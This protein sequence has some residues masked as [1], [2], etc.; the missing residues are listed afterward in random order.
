MSL[1][2]LPA[3]RVMLTAGPHAGKT[4]LL[5]QWMA[6][7]PTETLYLSLTPEDRDPEFFA[8]RLLREQPKAYERFVA[9]PRAA[10]GDRLAA[11]LEVL[12]VLSIFLDDAHAIEDS[13]LVAGLVVLA[14]HL[15]PSCTLVVASRH[16]IPAL[17]PALEAVWGAEHPAWDERP[18]FADLVGLPLQLLAKAFSLAL[19]GEAPP[20]PEG[21]ELIR[22]NVAEQV[23]D[24]H[25]LRRPWRQAMMAFPSQ[26]LAPSVW[27]VV[28]QDLRTFWDLNR[29]TSRGE[30]MLA[31]L[32]GIPASIRALR[33]TL[34][35]I[36]GQAYFDAF[37][38][39]S[40]Y[41]SFE[42]ALALR[43]A[44]RHDQLNLALQR[45]E[46]RFRLDE[47]PDAAELACIPSAL[48]D[49]A[50]LLRA[51]AL[52]NQGRWHAI[53]GADAEAALCWADVAGMGAKP[54][55]GLAM[56][57]IRA[58]ANLHARATLR[59]DLTA[60]RRHR[61]RI[62]VLS[63]RWGFE[64]S[65]PHVLL[66]R[67]REENLDES[68][69]P[70]SQVRWDPSVPFPPGMRVYTL[71]YLGQRARYLGEHGLALR[72]FDH[73]ERLAATHAL[74]YEVQLA[75]LGR[76][77]VHAQSGELLR[78][79]AEY[80]A[81]EFSSAP[82]SWTDAARLYW[83]HCL[84][85]LGA[86]DE[87]DRQIPTTSSAT[88]RWQFLRRW[89]DHLQGKGSLE[90]IRALVETP[91]G[92]FLK[93][94]E[95]R[96]L[97]ALGLATLPPIFKLRVFGAFEVVRLGAP[98]PAWPRRRS[99][100]LLAMLGL[101]PGGLETRELSERIFWDWLPS[102]PR[103]SLHVLSHAARKALRA[104]EGEHLIETSRGRQRLVG[105]AF[106]YNELGEFEHFFQQGMRDE[107][108][109]D[110]DLAAFWYTIA[111][112]HVSGDPCENLPELEPRLR[113]ALRARLQRARLGAGFPLR[114]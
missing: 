14:A 93:R 33:P 92:R 51:R 11:A 2:M 89:C 18:A 96:A 31:M 44:A 40:A 30:A 112:H 28:E 69:P 5:R 79:R 74:S 32:A 113:E 50:P 46:A 56:L 55:R 97:E 20:S 80:E 99:L 7:S 78:A 103:G 38:Y 87:A 71:E 83:A 101:Q 108:K 12:P 86:Y 59:D 77:M 34:L 81:L 13:P 63:R 104:I 95:A 114:G 110:R 45:L 107:E 8:Y 35:E 41:A 48:A 75:R 24:R 65:I 66:A 90:A 54:D 47:A 100:A 84:L 73:Q 25:L 58:E 60:A 9:D 57:G 64:R 111:L 10:W 98:D 37:D 4:R 67:C 62:L 94:V 22:R 53:Q 85:E 72:F 82:M 88:V 6:E 49:P 23:S 21:L 36:E 15:S 76:M 42:R 70:I 106:A 39:E 68:R 109:G 16:R 52:L 1:T 105:E 102:D 29:W 27:E 19:V 61:R 91:E 43:P 26:A 17:E 3:R